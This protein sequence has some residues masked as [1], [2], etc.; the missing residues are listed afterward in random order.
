MTLQVNHREEP[1]NER[2]LN[3]SLDIAGDCGVMHSQLSGSIED[4]V[5]IYGEKIN[6]SPCRACCR[7]LFASGGLA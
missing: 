4:L 1:E 6:L 2:V 5:E 3:S 7:K